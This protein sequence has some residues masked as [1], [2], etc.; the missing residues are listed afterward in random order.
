MKKLLF[1]VVILGLVSMNLKSF[2]NDNKKVLGSWKVEVPNAPYEYTKSTLNITESEGKLS[3]QIVFENENSTKASSVNFAND[4]LTFNVT[5]E[6]NDIPFSGK[7]VGNKMTGSV[8]TPDGTMELTAE[9][10][11]LKGTWSFQAP[12]APYDYQKGKLAFSEKSGV[13]SAKVLLSDNT[14][15]NVQNLKIENN[16]FKFSMM[17]EGENV[18]VSGKLVNGK[19]VAK[20]ITSDGE[21][22][23]TAVY[24][25]PKN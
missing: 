11:S 6:N 18:S 4:L 14:E 2:G 10:I 7:L 16:S 19:I 17:A 24:V 5:V 23:A 1:A 9:K 22:D 8:K 12:N 21:L 25:K 20:A 15:I 3:A 13:M